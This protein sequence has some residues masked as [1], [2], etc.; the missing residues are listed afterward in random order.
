[1][2]RT[3]PPKID[4]RILTFICEFA[5]GLNEDEAAA[6][7]GLPLSECRRAFLS[8]KA[9]KRVLEREFADRLAIYDLVPVSIIRAKIL[10]VLA[11]EKNPP[12]ARCRRQTAGGLAD[13][14]GRKCRQ[15][16]GRTHQNL[17]QERR[18]GRRKKYRKSG[19]K[20]AFLWYN[21]CVSDG[22]E[23]QRKPP[24]PFLSETILPKQHNPKR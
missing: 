15:E 21:R 8:R 9:H 17:A 18:A 3:N 1:M 12:S 22:G 13:R 5:N 23:Q 24:A 19:V 16:C 6:K 11:N 14:R 10:G 4:D 2:P 20:A 7:A